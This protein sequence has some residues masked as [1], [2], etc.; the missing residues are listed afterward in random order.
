[1][2]E[3][4]RLDA[5]GF[6]LAHCGIRSEIEWWL[7]LDDVLR[8]S[9]SGSRL[10]IGRLRL[11]DRPIDCVEIMKWTS[12]SE[13]SVTIMGRER[14]KKQ[15]SYED[16]FVIQ[17]SERRLI[18]P[19]RARRKPKR[20]LWIVGRVTDYQWRGTRFAQQL[21]ADAHLNRMLAESG[22]QE[23]RIKYDRRASCIRVVRPYIGMTQHVE[24][25]L[26]RFQAEMIPDYHLPTP[27]A[28]AAYENIARQARAYAGLARS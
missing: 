6:Y 12:S 13:T 26:L 15:L 27:E 11:Y 5:W 22:E 10:C 23:I 2:L 25:S 21:A 9:I 20:S 24:S 18:D 1:M 28:L 8:G 19:P 14:S 16:H 4:D 3:P 17:V 7:A